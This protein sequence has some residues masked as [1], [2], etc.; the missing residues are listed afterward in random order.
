MIDAEI[1][2]PSKKIPFNEINKIYN[3]SIEKYNK[4]KEEINKLREEMIIKKELEYIELT[5]NNIH[6]GKSANIDNFINRMKEDFIKR[7]NYKYSNIQKKENENLKVV[8]KR[9]IIT[10][11][12]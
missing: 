5:K 10:Q 6:N 7:S 2:I 9:V 3:K 1:H 12:K 8:L 4:K 11:K